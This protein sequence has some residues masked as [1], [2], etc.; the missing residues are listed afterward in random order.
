MNKNIG[1][2][3]KFF[4]LT[5]RSGILPGMLSLE[6]RSRCRDLSRPYFHALGL[7]LVG[8]GLGLGLVGKVSVSVSWVLVSVS[9]DSGLGL[10]TEIEISSKQWCTSKKCR[11]TRK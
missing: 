2:I 10:E 4:G 7:G 6:T 3:S 11:P 9:P 8:S 5:F 1:I